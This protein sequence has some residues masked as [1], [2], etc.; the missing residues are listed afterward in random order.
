[1][2]FT[3]PIENHTS[4]ALIVENKRLHVSKEILSVHSPVFSALFFQDF[5]EKAKE[6]VEIKEVDYDQFVDFLNVIYPTSTEIL[7][8]T[9]GY[10]LT[11]AD[12]FQ[13]E[14]ALDKAESYLLTT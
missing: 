10:I 13:V 2:D 14:C 8:R 9:V 6:V 4:I 12:R 11:L 3:K 5:A 1:I 7:A